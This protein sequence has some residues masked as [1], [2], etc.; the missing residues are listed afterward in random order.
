MKP[1]PKVVIPQE[2]AHEMLGFSTVVL[3]ANRTVKTVIDESLRMI[4][5]NQ[6]TSLLI[7]MGTKEN[8]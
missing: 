5:L 4:S 1:L 3:D 7:L 6:I 2:K 8:R